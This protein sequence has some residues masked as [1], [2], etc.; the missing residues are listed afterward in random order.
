MKKLGNVLGF[1]LLLALMLSLLLPLETAGAG[2]SH[3]GKGTVLSVD[4]QRSRIVITEGS[5]GTRVLYLNAQTQVIGETGAP[6]RVGRLQPGDVIREE[7]FQTGDVT[8]VA[9]QIR[10][11]RQAWM[12]SASFEQ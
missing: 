3:S 10:V 5:Q 1:S 12:D 6:I 9:K 7:C 11:L 2:A 8:F 4:L